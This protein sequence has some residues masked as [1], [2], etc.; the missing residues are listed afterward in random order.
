VSIQAA[1][2]L[3]GTQQQGA[4]A[5]DELLCQA[6]LRPGQVAELAL[7]NLPIG[8]GEPSCWLLSEGGSGVPWCTC[9]DLLTHL[10]RLGILAPTCS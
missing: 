3:L 9:T 1:D 10:Q 8:P 5:C 7:G 2:L 4:I 6:T